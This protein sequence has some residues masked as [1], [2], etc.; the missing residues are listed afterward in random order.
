MLLTFGLGFAIQEFNLGK[1]WCI[2]DKF[3][4]CI[5]KIFNKYLKIFGESYEKLWRN[6]DQIL[7]NV[8]TELKLL[9]D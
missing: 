8:E 2:F 6:F 9:E 7:G 5:L 4:E 1:L 3:W